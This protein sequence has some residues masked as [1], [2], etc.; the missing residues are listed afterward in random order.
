[1]QSIKSVAKAKILSISSHFQGNTKNFSM[2]SFSQKWKQ[3]KKQCEGY[4]LYPNGE[5][6]LHMKCYNF[7]LLWLDKSLV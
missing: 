4:S 5:I 7:N 2:R 1:M 6:I 3:K